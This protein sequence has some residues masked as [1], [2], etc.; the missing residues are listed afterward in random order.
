MIKAQWHYETSIGCVNNNQKQSRLEIPE[1]LW[2]FL[3][4][5]AVSI[6]DTEASFITEI[7]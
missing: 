4:F 6:V 5:F 7:Y 3:W 2:I 1:I